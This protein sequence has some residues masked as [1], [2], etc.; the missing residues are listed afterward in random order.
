MP[1]TRYQ[2]STFAPLVMVNFDHYERSATE[3]RPECWGAYFNAVACSDTEYIIS[4]PWHD[5][6]PNRQLRVLLAT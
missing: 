2:T 3:R 5:A 6:E 1:A 4:S